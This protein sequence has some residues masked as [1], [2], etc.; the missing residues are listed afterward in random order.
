MATRQTKAAATA[1]AA[2]TAAPKVYRVA[3]ARSVNFRGV[4]LGPQQSLPR[5]TE[6]M[7]AELG[8][9]VLEKVEIQDGPEV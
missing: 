1:A 9:A 7:L 4:V 2:P 5:V 3:L 8:D 6:D